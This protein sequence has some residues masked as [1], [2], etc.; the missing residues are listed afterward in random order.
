MTLAQPAA[1]GLRSH[2]RRER[3]AVKAV[4]CHAACLEYRLT[5]SSQVGLNDDDLDHDGVDN[6]IRARKKD[7]ITPFTRRLH[8]ATSQALRPSARNRQL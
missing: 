1:A 3:N 7:A 4:A 8:A 2:N 6:L 5:K